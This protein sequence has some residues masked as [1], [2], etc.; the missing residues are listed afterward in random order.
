MYTDALL[1]GTMSFIFVFLKAFQQRNVAFEHYAAVMPLSLMMGLAEYTMIG[2]IAVQAAQMSHSWLTALA[3]GAGAGLGALLA[4]KIH[5][6]VFGRK[7]DV[8]E[9]TDT[10]VLGQSELNDH[11]VTH[12]ADVLRN[13]G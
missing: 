2:V 12:R 7:Y 6:R 13:K 8:E 3:M 5:T 9:R 11:R 1:V 10:E 4:I